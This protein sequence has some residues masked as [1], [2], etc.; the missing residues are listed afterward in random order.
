M[1]DV[2]EVSGSAGDS[3]TRFAAVDAVP[4]LS[5]DND[6]QL[7]A[8]AVTVREKRSRGHPHAPAGGVLNRRGLRR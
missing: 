1:C 3:E 4:M 2:F 8:I 5:I 7:T 6:E